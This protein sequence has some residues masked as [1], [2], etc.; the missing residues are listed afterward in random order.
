MRRL[1]TLRELWH[2][3]PRRCDKRSNTLAKVDAKAHP[4]REEI[5]T[6]SL[7]NGLLDRQTQLVATAFEVGMFERVDIVNLDHHDIKD[8]L[9]VSDA[10]AAKLIAAGQVVLSNEYGTWWGLEEPNSFA[11]LPK[12]G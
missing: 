3:R 12:L 5:M 9:L 4:T 10:L 2:E 8:W 1:T 11:T 6:R 7:I